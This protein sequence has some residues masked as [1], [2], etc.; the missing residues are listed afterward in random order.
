[1]VEWHQ[2]WVK[3]TAVVIRLNLQQNQ[4]SGDRIY[5]NEIN[6]SFRQF[7]ASLTVKDYFDETLLFF[8]FS[9]FLYLKS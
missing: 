2:I 9:F 5:T 4:K 1:M 7:L 3:V 6:S 8:N